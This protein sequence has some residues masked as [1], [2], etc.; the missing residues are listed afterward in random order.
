MP[1]W[2]KAAN[3]P[4]AERTAQASRSSPQPAS[5]PRRPCSKA[6][7]HERRRPS[8]RPACPAGSGVGQEEVCRVVG[9]RPVPP[10]GRDGC[11]QPGHA[12][13]R[14]AA[15]VLLPVPDRGQCAGRPADGQH[16]VPVHR[17]ERPGRG[18]CRSPVCL[19]GGHRQC[20]RR[21]RLDGVLRVRRD[22]RGHGAP[23]D[24]RA[25]LRSAAP[26]DDRRPAPAGLA[27][28]ADRHLAADRLGGT[29]ATARRRAGASGGRRPGLVTGFWWLTMRTLLAGRISWRALFRPPAPP[30]CCT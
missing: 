25:G 24:L 6:A 16:T 2:D 28:R 14:H 3:G 15:V 5:G 19:L 20:R 22:R 1:A 18:R 21:D 4:G 26:G 13:R 9:G 11:H 10:T 27:G 23:R 8:G 30:A 29:R 7:R 12:V 17:P